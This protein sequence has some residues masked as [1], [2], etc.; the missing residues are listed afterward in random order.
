MDR[1]DQG[2]MPANRAAAAGEPPVSAV[3][4]ATGVVGLAGLMIALAVIAYLRLPLAAAALISLTATF[5]PMV[6]WSVIVEKVWKNP[7]TGLDFSK[8]RSHEETMET[9]KVKLIGLF[10]TWVIICFLYFV[11]ANYTIKKFGFYYLILY[12]CA[13]P[14]TAFALI[15]V[16]YV[17]M[18][19]RDPKDA[20][21][22]FGAWICGRRDETDRE[23]LLDHMRAWAVKGFFLAFM[24]PIVP[25]N[26]SAFAHFNWN[27]ITAS[28]V[29][30]FLA[31]IGLLYSIDV[32]F[33]T[34]GYLATF[35]L[36]DSHIRRAN[37]YA[38]AWLFA[39]ICYPPFAAG[40]IGGALNYRIGGGDWHFWLADYPVAIVV[41]GILLV[42]LTAL[43]A[44]ATIIFGIR[45]S[46][47]TDRGIITN[48]PYR[49]FKHPAYV[50]KNLSW[51]L[52]YLPFLSKIDAASGFRACVLLAA[53]NCIYYLRARSEEKQLMADPDYRAYSEWIAEHGLLERAWRWTKGK[54][55]KPVPAMQAAE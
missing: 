46:N 45:F 47:L 32:V 53:V 2:G 40:I 4:A 39:L 25:E 26:M 49:Y 38:E 19:M 44:S 36:L 12:H 51:W 34:I 20:L 11:L 24:V 37:P 9:T 43:Y 14:A 30:W 18:H 27:A 31:I 54:F 15:Y 42:A 28:P 55:A 10:V 13:L 48:G 16:Y 33:G 22:H 8:P 52:M 7:S 1:V 50:S 6:L 21:W 17:D 23:K 41:W 3:S 29:A 35:R 5:L